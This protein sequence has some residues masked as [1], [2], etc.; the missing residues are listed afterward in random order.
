MLS[1]VRTITCRT[2][3]FAINAAG[4]VVK[5]NS[6]NTLADGPGLRIR[7]ITDY[8]G[9]NAAPAS[10]RNYSYNEGTS[11]LSNTAVIG[12]RRRTAW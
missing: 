12:K 6:S 4:T 1:F 5:T 2:P 11:F 7:N 8:D 3:G 9:V 10:V